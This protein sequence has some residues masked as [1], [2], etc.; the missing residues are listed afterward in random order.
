MLDR[1]SSLDASG[2]SRRPSFLHKRRKELEVQETWSADFGAGQWSGDVAVPRQRAG[3]MT[4][5]R[6]SHRRGVSQYHHHSSS[7]RTSCSVM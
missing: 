5:Q 2:Q 6:A 4:G 3:S 7:S 1:Y